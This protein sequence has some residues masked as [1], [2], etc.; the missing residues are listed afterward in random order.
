VCKTSVKQQH[1]D[2]E[3]REKVLY[4]PPGADQEP[5]SHEM[6]MEAKTRKGN[7]QEKIV[8]P[9]AVTLGPGPYNVVET[10]VPATNAS[11]GCTRDGG[12]MGSRGRAQ[13]GALRLVAATATGNRDQPLAPGQNQMHS[14]S[15]GPAMSPQLLSRDSILFVIVLSFSDRFL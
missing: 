9:R 11:T 14:L 8:R 15:A 10:N 13:G 12:S 6:E 4:N 2:I 5:K 3:E 1:F 7:I